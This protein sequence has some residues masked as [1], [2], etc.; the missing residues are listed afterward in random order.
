MR[1]ENGQHVDMLTVGRWY[2]ENINL[3]EASHEGQFVREGMLATAND[4]GFNQ[5]YRAFEMAHDILANGMDP[6]QIRSEPPK[7]RPF[8]VNRIRAEMLSISL[9]D[10]LDLI[11]EMVEETVAPEDSTS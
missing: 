6:G 3:P 5:S 9:D 1:D 2:L 10:K 11:D 8:M 4:S 7:R